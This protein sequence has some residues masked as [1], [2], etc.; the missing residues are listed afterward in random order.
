MNNADKR[1]GSRKP[2]SELTL[3][4][5]FLFDTA[6]SI[7]EVARN[8]LS[9]IMGEE[10]PEISVGISEKSIEPY[11]DSRSIRLDLLAVDENNVIYD[12]E[13]QPSKKDKSDYYRRSRF[14]Q[15]VI[16]ASLLKPGAIR[17]SDLNDLYIIFISPYD[18]FGEN[19]YRY[20]FQPACK[21]VSGLYLEDGATRIFLNTKGI[22]DED[23][24]PELIEFLH[25]MEYTFQQE[26]TDF[27]S[28]R[29]SR[30]AKQIREI[31]QNQKVGVK[32]MRFLEELEIEKA[33]AREISRAEG[34]AEGLIEGKTE[35]REAGIRK[36][37]SGARKLGASEQQI[38][39]LLKEEYQISEAD[40]EK[41][42]TKV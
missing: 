6:M 5:R 26:H 42:L 11:Y 4:D 34:R 9:I 7:P 24:S 16:D 10:L 1:T 31:K 35:E 38:K 2:F 28:P 39:N 36:L 27:K 17:F 40:A 15:G 41:Y 13:A 14:Y 22:N 12:A 30:L 19:L 8:I 23:E 21:E 37:V 33:E 3:L 29:V 20:T 32:Y 18:L 25:A